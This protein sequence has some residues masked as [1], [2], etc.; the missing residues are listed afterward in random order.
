MSMEFDSH[1]ATLQLSHPPETLA[2]LGIAKPEDKAAGN[3]ERVKR[4][5]ETTTK[6]VVA[7]YVVSNEFHDEQHRA[8]CEQMGIDQSLSDRTFTMR[9]DGSSASVLRRGVQIREDESVYG[10]QYDL[11]QVFYDTD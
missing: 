2:L 4:L 3:A 5:A 11:E 10:V 7:Y 9:A 6:G 8:F 1:I